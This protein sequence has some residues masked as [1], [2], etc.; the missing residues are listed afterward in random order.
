MYLINDLRQ[1]LKFS[2]CILFA[3]DTTIYIKGGN[4]HCLKVKLQSDLD[5]ICKWLKVNNLVLN[6]KKTKCM[7]FCH[8]GYHHGLELFMNGDLIELVDTFKF[9]GIWWD[10]H[11]D[12]VTHAKKY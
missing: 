9:L 3:D 10:S 1:C 11:L 2:N 8:E 5:S 4:L 7:L 12:F 6:T